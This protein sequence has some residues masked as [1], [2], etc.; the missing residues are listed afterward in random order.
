MMMVPRITDKPPILNFVDLFI[1]ELEVDTEQTDRRTIVR[2]AVF[3]REDR[4]AI[5][6]TSNTL[7]HYISSNRQCRFTQLC[8]N[9]MVKR[10]ID[11]L[12]QKCC[13]RKKLIS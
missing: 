12:A 1:L 3:Y 5:N 13:Y 11:Q 10:K 4:I 2:N 9:I 7:K 6:T 8:T